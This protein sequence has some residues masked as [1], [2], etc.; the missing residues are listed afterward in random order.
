MDLANSVV[1]CLVTLVVVNLEKWRQ[2]KEGRKQ[3]LQEQMGE[4]MEEN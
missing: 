2:L 3:V 4:I 1:W